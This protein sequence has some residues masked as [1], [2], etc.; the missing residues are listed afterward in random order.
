M[1]GKNIRRII[2][3]ILIGIGLLGSMAG[4]S[5]DSF[6]AFAKTDLVTIM[7]S[8]VAANQAI[9]NKLYTSGLISEAEKKEIEASID[10]QMSSYMT[11]ISNNSK[12]QKKLLNAA[13]DWSAPSWESK[14]GPIEQEYIDENGKTQVKYINSLGYTEEEWNNTILTL[15]MR[16]SLNL[17]DWL[18]LF[19]GKKAK[20][21]PIQLIDSKTGDMINKRF[22]YTIFVLKPF[23]STGGDIQG[24]S[25]DEVIEMVEAATKDKKSIDNSVLD[26]L[27]QSTG[28]TLLDISKRKNQVVVDSNGSPYVSEATFKMD[29]N[30]LK[31]KDAG[32]SVIADG[33]DSAKAS[34]KVPLTEAK[35][36]KDMVVSVANGEVPI[37]ALRFHEFNS[38][39]VDNIIKTLGMSPDQY[40]FTTYNGENRVYIMEYPVHYVSGMKEDEKDKTKY[41]LT[42]SVSHIGINLRTGK[43]TKYSTAWR[44]SKDPAVYME[45]SDP[46]LPVAG[47]P[48]SDSDGQSAFIIEGETPSNA[49]LEVGES[50]TK[51]KTGRIILRDYLEATYAPGVVDDEKLVVF[52]RKIRILSFKGSKNNIVAKYYDKEGKPIENSAG[53]RI[54]DF[55]D[56][57]TLASSKPKI[58]YISRI[59]E[60]TA[61][62]G[63]NGDSGTNQGNSVIESSIAKIDD[64]PKSTVSNIIPT[65]QFPGTVI[66]KAD[67]SNSNKPLFYTLV[68]KKNMFETALFSDWINKETTESNSLQWWSKW[69]HDENRSYNYAINV[70][71]LE[72][73][74]KGNYTF[75]LQEEGIVVLNLDIVA[76][77]Q[78]EFNEQDRVASSKGIR[79]S[80]VVFGYVLIL[81][82]FLLLF[83]WL[84]DTNID[85]GLKLLNKLSF[86]NWEAII[87]K[88]EIPAYDETTQKYVTFS[89]VVNKALIIAIVG[90]ILINI[91]VLDLVI[92]IIELFGGI[93][94][95][96]GSIVTGN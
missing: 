52:G 82:A 75:E 6:E 14:G 73:Y 25:L 61:D 50:K 9:V 34:L 84:F 87:D 42:L 36:G 44:N 11:D 51:V 21:E 86:G 3:S 8:R 32:N 40:L 59:G 31:V 28:T 74:L 69:L 94:K 77:I 85:I 67:N 29:G 92:L 90:V 58:K 20:I 96:L 18:P 48:N 16:E 30:E 65:N 27:F 80:F 76:K 19:Q 47:A 62:T 33:I 45:D 83:S 39:A 7:T 68:V 37:M 91:N 46:Y 12:L 72:N 78:N 41:E 70:S 10:K 88:G 24:K 38:D 71:T 53:L 95:V 63:N 2:G 56:S 60:S 89:G 93:A 79:T 15:Y 23:G 26:T 17:A 64:L 66:G 57:N 5:S 49:L 4:C 43:L 13:V 55:A 35:P 54:D 22:G 1:V 81:Y